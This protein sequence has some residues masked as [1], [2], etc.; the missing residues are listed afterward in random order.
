MKSATWTAFA[1]RH[2]IPELGG[3]RLIGKLVIVP[4]DEWVLRAI[5]PESSNFSASLFCLQALALPMY[6]PTRHVYFT[7]GGRIGALGGKAE[8]WWDTRQDQWQETAAAQAVRE[9]KQ[10]FADVNGPAGLATY[11]ERRLLPISPRDPNMREVLAYSQLLAGVD[12][13]VASLNEAFV[14]ASEARA[15]WAKEIVDR[16]SEVRGAISTGQ[17]SAVT[18]LFSKWRDSNRRLLHLAD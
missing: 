3:A 18:E 13:A 17:A 15:P 7:Y 10:F 1:K 6:V 12:T 5:T 14:I 4:N 16:I 9:A 2:L 8:M 11:I